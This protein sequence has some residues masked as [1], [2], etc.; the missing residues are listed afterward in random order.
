MNHNTA[1]LCDAHSDVIQI[2]EPMF[3]DFGGHLEFHGSISTVKC[4]ED[5]SLVRA[6]L[7]TPG[8]GGVLVVDGGASMR[9]ALVG[10]QLA[11]LA[12]RNGWRGIIVYGCIR[13]SFAIG[14]IAV[15]VKALDTHPLRSLKKG[16]G[17]RDV[18]VRFAG[19][20]FT[21]GEFVYADTD[22]IIAA[23]TELSI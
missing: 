16:A 13:D 18:P 6:A 5:N 14:E 2:A 3:A 1:E 11:A 19:I 12:H 9:C 10:D 4:F 17:E 22:G 21:P 15:G 7:E 8:D 20:T 23:A